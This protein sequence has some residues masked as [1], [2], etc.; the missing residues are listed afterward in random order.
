MELTAQPSGHS[1]VETGTPADWIA[2]AHLNVWAYREFALDLG[3]E[4]WPELVRTLTA[5]APAAETATF[6][7]VREDGTL[8]GSAAYRPPG[9]SLSPIPGS[10][11]SVDLLAVSPAARNEGIATD[12]VDACLERARADGAPALGAHVKGFMSAAQELFTRLG[13]HRE[14][15]LAR[16]DEHPY[17][18]YRRE[19]G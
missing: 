3:P 11:A 18:L 10:W 2:I 6:L 15:G 5:V 1:S 19:L 16:R 14:Q 17:W 7:V 8:T 9:A 4:V 13:F 12:L